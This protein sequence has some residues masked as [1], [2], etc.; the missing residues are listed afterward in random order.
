MTVSHDRNSTR[1]YITK[2]EQDFDITFPF[3]NKD[4][5][6]VF[7]INSSGQQILLKEDSDYLISSIE[8]HR[9]KVTL[10][11]HEK[12]IQGD[13]IYINRE[14]PFRQEIDYPEGGPFPAA[15]HELGLDLSVMRDQQLY[16][17]LTR[18]LLVPITAK[19]FKNH[20]PVPKAHRTLVFNEDGTSL[21]TGPRAATII[22]A[23]QALAQTINL[24]QQAQNA[25]E[26]AGEAADKLAPTSETKLGLVRLATQAETL[27][28]TNDQHAITPAS[29]H[30]SVHPPEVT[31]FKTAGSHSYTVPNWARGIWVQIWGAGGGGAGHRAYSKD[32]YVGGGSGG[33]YASSLLQLAP[34]TTTSIT[35]GAGGRGGG[36]SSSLGQAGGVSSFGSYLSATG[37][38]TQLT[39]SYM[40]RPGG[41]GRGGNLFNLDGGMGALNG[42]GGG[43]PFGALSMQGTH[44]FNLNIPGAHRT[45]H[46]PGGGGGGSWPNNNG[47]DGGAIIWAYSALLLPALAS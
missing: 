44:Y 21:V 11:D 43:T 24:A 28:G 23:E 41:Q 22:Q 2:P 31:I 47:A 10:K 45:G 15:S 42:L 37:G 12:F 33:G 29:L 8:D 46:W 19:K 35:I 3:F 39:R 18:C 14:V 4:H 1:Y 25:A 40:I 38:Q 16:E 27:T 30:A 5:I 32:Q 34:G 9:Q 26:R 7:H 6:R 13:L 20:L 17:L 36:T